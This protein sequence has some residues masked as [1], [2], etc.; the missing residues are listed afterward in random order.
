MRH[1]LLPL[2]FLTLA[3]VWLGPLPQLASQVFSAH[4]TMHMGVVA[5]AAPLLALGVAGGKLDPVR[6]APALFAPIP[7]SVLELVV[8][9]AWHTPALHHT[10]RHSPIG[11]VVEQGMFFL[12][13]L[14]V[15]LSAFGG[16][17]RRRGDRAGAGVVGL[18]LTSMHM[19]LLGALLALPPRPLYMHTDGFAGISPLQDQHL[20]GAI[21]LVVGGVSY[22]LGGLWLTVGL[23]K[24]AMP[25][26]GERV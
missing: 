7:A 10:A 18:L 25:E 6:K 3:A 15:W 2:G 11:L 9:W 16:D 19:T 17:A 20:G 5:V 24:G 13:G 21:M 1:T 23:L 26:R 8:V 12:A 22:L 4:M 14:L